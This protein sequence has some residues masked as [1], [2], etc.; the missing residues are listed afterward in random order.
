MTENG[1]PWTG[2]SFSSPVK[3]PSSITWTRPAAL[4]LWRSDP[5]PL[6]PALAAAFTW[7]GVGTLR[8]GEERRNNPEEGF[9]WQHQDPSASARRAGAGRLTSPTESGL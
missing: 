2:W 6:S 8:R 4:G 1:F 3:P 9:K 7:R 5:P